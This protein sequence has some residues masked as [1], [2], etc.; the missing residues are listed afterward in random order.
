M[1]MLLQT[2]ISQQYR[3]SDSPEKRQQANVYES[4]QKFAFREPN[5]CS[6][7]NNFLLRVYSRRYL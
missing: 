6:L 1:R 4:L 7:R 5:L 2:K 3:T